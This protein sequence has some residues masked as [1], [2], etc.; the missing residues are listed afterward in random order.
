MHATVNLTPNKAYVFA[1]GLL[2]L[3]G[4]VFVPTRNPYGRDFGRAVV[5]ELLLLNSLQWRA[6]SLKTKWRILASFCSFLAGL[7]VV[8]AYTRVPFSGF[9]I[10]FIL[11]M[12]AHGTALLPNIL[13]LLLLSSWDL[14]CD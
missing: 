4:T 10:I 8:S 7:L 6:F 9:V 1:L 3:T 12:R 14:S 13:P 11:G 5:V 2:I